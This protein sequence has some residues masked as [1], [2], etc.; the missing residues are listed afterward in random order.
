MQIHGSCHAQE[1]VKA[2]VNEVEAHVKN[3]HWELV[4]R[5][6]APSDMD[7]LPAIWDMKQQNLT[8]NKIKSH[9]TRLNIH[10]GKQAYGTNYY[11]TYAVTW[12]VKHFMI[13]LAIFLGLAMRQIDFVQAYAQAPIKCDMYM[14][15]PLGIHC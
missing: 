11:E 14:E 10:G 6:Q 4:K 1:F 9:K 15:L 8:T 2:I 7:I 12:F 13:I 3:N 5:D